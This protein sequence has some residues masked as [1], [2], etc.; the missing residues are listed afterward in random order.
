MND[1]ERRQ[2]W[3]RFAASVY[4]FIIADPAPWEGIAPH[5]VAAEYADLMLTELEERFGVQYE[6]ERIR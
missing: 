5:K 3:V 1:V 6:P 2:A 4:G